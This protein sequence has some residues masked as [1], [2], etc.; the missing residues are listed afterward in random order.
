MV[1]A[2]TFS[3]IYVCKPF[4]YGDKRESYIYYTYI[5]YEI[6]LLHSMC[7]RFVYSR[8]SETNQGDCSLKK[9]KALYWNIFEAQ[10]AEPKLDNSFY[11]NKS[12]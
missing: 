7:K 1:L 3:A 8:D 12:I 5:Y 4:S 2:S 6:P 10:L 11:K 9:T